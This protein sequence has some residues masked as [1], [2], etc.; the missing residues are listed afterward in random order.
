MDYAVNQSRFSKAIL[1]S[2]F[3]GFITTII[4]L[5][6]NLIFRYST[7]YIPANFINVSSLIFGVNLCFLVIGIIY[8]SCLHFFRKG[9]V[10]FEIVLLLV[11]AL[12][13][14]KAAGATMQHD[15]HLTIEF[16]ELLIGVIALMA[17]G[18]ILIP[19]FYHSRKFL[20]DIV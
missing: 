19:Y 17:I 6:Y 9:D 2:V 8:F 5:V 7:H 15:H 16:R 20:E 18:S 1:T 12:C 3:I 13:I 10:V 11:I 14:W 4:C